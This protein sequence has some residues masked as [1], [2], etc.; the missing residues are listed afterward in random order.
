[1]A[2]RGTTNTEIQI[3]GDGDVI[4]YDGRV[5]EIFFLNNSQRFLAARL[6]YD[7]GTPDRSGA[8]IIQMWATKA[9]MVAMVRVEAEH[10]AAVDALLAQI[11][12]S[13]PA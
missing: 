13:A 5:L 2:E 8:V 4:V 6:R 7:R 11:A 12:G 3:N 9:Q 1:M 10:V